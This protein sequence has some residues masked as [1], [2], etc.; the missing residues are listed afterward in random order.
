[1]KPLLVDWKELQFGVEIE[2]VGGNPENVD[3]LPGWIMS[4]DERQIEDTG[5]ESGSELKPPP[6]KWEDREQIREMLTRLQATGAAVNWNCGLHVHVGLELWGQEI[7]PQF[8]EAALQYQ[9]AV[10]CLLN[11]GE[12]RLIFCPPVTR[13][14][15]DRFMSDPGRG[16][17]RRKG[18]PQSHRCGINLAAWF[19][20]GTAETRYAN[21]SLNY[22]EVINTIEFCL[23]FV[24]AIGSG[25][26][27]SCDPHIMAI[28]LSAPLSGYP[29]PIPA[30]RW[31][32]ERIWLE[33]ALVPI[34]TPLASSLVQ[35]GEIHHILPR[36]DGILVAIEDADGKVCTY[37][38]HLPSTGWEVARQLPE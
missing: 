14:M 6:I 27:L 13:E 37:L 1:M 17:L 12:D 10:R 32:R 36:P 33:N 15:R 11:T 35:D 20:I 8:I 30:P 31:Y 18:R 23:R 2:F 28:E 19:D 16:A 3:L 7:I 34:L 9:E 38:F 21:G 24:A 29:Q 5:E 4:F 22:N 26:K 25:R